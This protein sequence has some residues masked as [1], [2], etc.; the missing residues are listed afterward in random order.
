MFLSLGCYIYFHHLNG[1]ASLG[2]KLSIPQIKKKSIFKKF[3]KYLIHNNRRTLIIH[4]HTRMYIQ[5]DLDLTKSRNQAKVF[6]I[7]KI[8]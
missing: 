8:H 4:I 7:L 3:S 2:Y 6:V 1:S 5:L